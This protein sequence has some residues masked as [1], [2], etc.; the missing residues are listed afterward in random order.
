[1]NPQL[2]QT[3]LQR[4]LREVAGEDR[5][6]SLRSEAPLA[7]AEAAMERF[8]APTSPQPTIEDAQ[9]AVEKTMV[10]APLNEAEMFSIEAIVLPRERPVVFIENNTFETPESPWTHFAT[11]PQIKGRL[12]AAIRSIGRVELPD[13][14]SIPFGGT[15]FVVGRDL[16]MTNRH[17]AELFSTGLGTRNLAFRTG[18]SAGWDPRRERNHQDGDD[19]TMLE[20]KQVVM[21]HPYWDMALLRV[22]GLTESQKPLE[23][24]VTRPE[25]LVNQDIAVIGYPAKDWRNDSELQDFIFKR[26]YNVK[27]LQPG[28]VKMRAEVQSFNNR[29]SAMTHDSSTL[30][31]NSGSALIN[32]ETGQVVGLHFAGRYL[33]ANFAVPTLN[34]R[35]IG[36]WWTWA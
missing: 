10:G 2:K 24:A 36:V 17:V 5:M 7:G 13:N 11:D 28:K 27:R 29:V 25:D 30:G 15:A 19:S 8:A 32:A 16:L 31:G 20:V 22:A 35:G 9:R 23:L 34:W 3:Q 6:E 14:L 21:I 12:E 33:L 4:F 1:M 18:Q 26:V